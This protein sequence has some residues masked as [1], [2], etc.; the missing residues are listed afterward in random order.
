MSALAYLSGKV[1]QAGDRIRYHGE[2]GYV[3]FVVTETSG[4]LAL[5][6]TLS[7]SLAAGP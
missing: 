4:D 5:T 6:G 3:D 2:Q 7:S 1:I